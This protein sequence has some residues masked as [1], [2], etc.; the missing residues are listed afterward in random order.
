MSALQQ[1]YPKRP[2]M[3]K[4][5]TES[6]HWTTRTLK[7]TSNASIT[8]LFGY[9][10]CSMSAFCV[11]FWHYW[12]FWVFLLFNVS[13][14]CSVYKNTQKRPVMS[15]HYT[16]SWHWTTRIP[17]KTSNAK[18]PH[19]KL[20][21]ILVAQCQLSVWCFGIT[22]L[23]GYSCC[24]MSSFCVEYSKKTSNVKTLHRKLT[25]SNKNTQKDQ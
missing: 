17:K 25:L 23:F 6:W 14:L 1:E 15:K 9:S 16:E 22:G 12:S 20:T 2:V 13:F 8:G 19:R 18:T 3:P 24:S 11:V 10:C 5:Y 21:G 7:K 4:H